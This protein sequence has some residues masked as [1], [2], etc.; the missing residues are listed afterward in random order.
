ML[1]IVLGQEFVSE[2]LQVRHCLLLA[3]SGGHS[4]ARVGGKMC[5]KGVN[6]IYT[7]YT[8]MIVANALRLGKNQVNHVE[9]SSR[10][11]LHIAVKS[12]IE[13]GVGTWGP[14]FSKKE[15]SVKRRTVSSSPAPVV[16][17]DIT[18]A[19]VP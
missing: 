5:E 15:E 10:F 8:H 2:G 7:M 9:C 6:I 1:L 19:Y 12:A 4:S 14:T 13:G 17:V 11:A 16:W 18:V 3:T